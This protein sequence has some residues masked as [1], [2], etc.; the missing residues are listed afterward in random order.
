MKVFE[1]E[2]WKASHWSTIGAMNATDEEILRWAR[3]NEYDEYKLRA[4][5]L[6]ISR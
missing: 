4:R 3:K 5:I 2:G 6:P 1:N